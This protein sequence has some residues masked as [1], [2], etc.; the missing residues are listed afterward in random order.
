MK[1]GYFDNEKREYVITR[2]DTPMSWI[3]YLGTPEYGALVSNNASGYSFYRS[4]ALQRLL[5][6]R[7]N[8]IPMDRPGRYI[9]IRDD[10]DGDYWSASWQPV[11]KDFNEYKTECR[12]GMGYTRFISEY[13]GIKSNYRVFVPLKEP[14]EFWELELENRSTETR[15]LSVFSFGEFCFWNIEQDLKNFQ[16][17]LYTCRMDYTDDI[18]DY[19][20]LFAGGEEPKA[21]MASTLPVSGFDTDRDLFIGNYH[22]E[23]NPVA[24]ER[25]QCFNSIAIGGNPCAVLHNKLSLNPGE[26]KWLLFIVGIGDAKKEGKAYKEKYSKQEAVEKEFQ[27]VQGYWQERMSYY[28]CETPSAEVNTMVNIWNQ[29]QC[30]M[31]FNWS[32]SAS[33]NEAGGRDGIGY[34]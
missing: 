4:P 12:H 27:A 7:F 28:S 18:I 17:I 32:R 2:P 13:R 8:S 11:A 21:F 34:R 6:F 24:V 25:G 22:H 3:N 30:H 15:E 16:Y 31:T 1:Y 5:R 26:K 9:Y 29:Y 14:I 20:L 19:S 10:Q 23:G 33:F